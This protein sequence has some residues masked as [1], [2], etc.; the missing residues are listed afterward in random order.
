MWATCEFPYGS[1]LWILWKS[2]NQTSIYLWPIIFHNLGWRVV[3][4][5]EKSLHR[6]WSLICIWKETKNLKWQSWEGRAFQAWEMANAKAQRREIKLNINLNSS[7]SHA[8]NM[9]SAAG[10]CH[11]YLPNTSPVPPF[12][13]FTKP[14]PWI[15]LSL[16]LTSTIAI[17]PKLVSLPQFSPL[18][19][20]FFVSPA[21]STGPD[22]VTWGI[23]VGES[24]ASPASFWRQFQ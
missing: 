10:C 6:I 11:V 3:R 7:L 18:A 2:I 5:S 20:H 14:L 9:N 24:K 17:V 16:P 22:W 19:G 1:S 13:R 21:P 4:E 23:T 15:N 8:L 12:S